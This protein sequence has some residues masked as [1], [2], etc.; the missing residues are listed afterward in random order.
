MTETAK[1]GR[2]W[3]WGIVVVILL[4]VGWLIGFAIF[5]F[6]QDVNLVQ[7][8]YY[9]KDMN[10]EEHLQRVAL[11][12]KL[13][14]KPQ[15][16]FQKDLH[17]LE[18]HFPTRLITD[19]ISGSIRVYRPSDHQADRLYPLGLNQDSVQVISLGGIESGHWRVMLDWESEGFGYYLEDSFFV[20]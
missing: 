11:T 10:Y 13:A 20:P 16:R 5:S 2:W 1:T 19:D 18:V 15:V 4:W 6:S 12:E 7:D 14:Q 3:L 17:V 8:H 9:E